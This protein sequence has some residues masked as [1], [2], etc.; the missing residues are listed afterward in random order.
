MRI[1]LHYTGV[2]KEI[3][4]QYIVDQPSIYKACGVGKQ[5]R[6]LL[7]Q[8]WWWERKMCLDK[9]GADGADK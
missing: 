5:K 2:R 7:P 1:I 9:E 3:I 4:F 8:Q 6:G